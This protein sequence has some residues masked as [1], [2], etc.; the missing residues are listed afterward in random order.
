MWSHK[1]EQIQT[2]EYFLVRDAAFDLEYVEI[3]QK[4]RQIC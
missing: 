2:I 1:K 3:L 4:L